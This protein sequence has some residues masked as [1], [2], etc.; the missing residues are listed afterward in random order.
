[1]PT[2]QKVDVEREVR[3]LKRRAVNFRHVIN[4]LTD[5]STSL[6]Q[7]SSRGQADPLL[8]VAYQKRD[9]RL[10]QRKAA[11]RENDQDPVARHGKGIHLAADIDRVRA[12]GST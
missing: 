11:A 9:D 1:L 12:C 2:Q 7:R 5:H 6:V 8:E 10:G 4:L 3:A